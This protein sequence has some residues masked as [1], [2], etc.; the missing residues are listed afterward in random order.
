MGPAM[1]S[2]L[3]KLT[4]D[5]TPRRAHGTL[6]NILNMGLISSLIPSIVLQE[7]TPAGSSNKRP[8]EVSLVTMLDAVMSKPTMAWTSVLLV[9]TTLLMLSLVPTTTETTISK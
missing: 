7:S 2:V 6:N 3:C 4:D 1:D 5:T 8:R 9:T